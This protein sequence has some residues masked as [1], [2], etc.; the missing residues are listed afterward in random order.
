MVQVKKC[1]PCFELVNGNR[2]KERTLHRYSTANGSRSSLVVLPLVL[3]VQQ[4]SV[5]RDLHLQAGLEV[6]QDVVI[7]LVPADVG[8]DLRHLVFQACDHV[9]EVCQLGSIAGLRLCQGVLQG[10]FLSRRGNEVG[11]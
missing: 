6:Q 9:L 11:R 7:L 1:L 3:S 10:S 2:E 4:P 5:F 8:E